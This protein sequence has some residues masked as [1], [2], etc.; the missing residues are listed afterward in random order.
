MI[1]PR[2]LQTVRLCPPNIAVHSCAAAFCVQ[3]LSNNVES[4]HHSI[5]D[6]SCAVAAFYTCCAQVVSNNVE[7]S[8]LR[9]PQEGLLTLCK[10]KEVQL[11]CRGVVLGGLLS[12]RW[13]LKSEKLL[14]AAL[15]AAEVRHFPEITRWAGGQKGRWDR[16][17]R[18]LKHTQEV[19]DKYS[20]TVR[21]WSECVCF[22]N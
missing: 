13:L 19:A 1:N 18:L 16:F 10:D 21:D 15:S 6:T 7:C 11:I 22:F 5:A 4:I 17:Q 12:D 20:T 14:S 8:M 2:P 3:V 9:R